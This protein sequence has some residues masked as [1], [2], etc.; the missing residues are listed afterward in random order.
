L[1]QRVPALQDRWKS[2]LD[3]LDMARYAPG[4]VPAPAALLS[5]AEALV[6]ATEKAWNA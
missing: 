4:Q 1:E 5:E 3:T 2:L 6:D